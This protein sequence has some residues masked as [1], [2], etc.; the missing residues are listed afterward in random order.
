MSFKQ[1]DS[2][3]IITNKKIKVYNLKKLQKIIGL[4]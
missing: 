1:N 2:W 3:L 4:G